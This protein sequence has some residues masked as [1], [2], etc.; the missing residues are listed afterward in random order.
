MILLV[1]ICG[2]C[3]VLGIVAY[4]FYKRRKM[5]IERETPLLDFDAAP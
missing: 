1:S 5:K 4:V 2:G 3:I